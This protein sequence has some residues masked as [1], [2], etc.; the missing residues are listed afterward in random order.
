[1][2]YLLLALTLTLTIAPVAVT[3]ADTPPS[4][5]P[6][7]TSSH[8]WKHGS[9]GAFMQQEMQLRRQFRS[10]ALSALSTD[11]R[12]A[13]AGIIGTM[14]VSASPDP[15]AAAAQIDGVLNQSER[16]AILSAR[17]SFKQQSLA[18]HQQMQ[19]QMAQQMPG[20]QSS[21]RPMRTPGPS[22]NDPGSILLMALAPESGMGMMHGGGGPH[23]WPGGPPQGAP[24][25]D[26]A[27][28][29]GP[30]PN[31]APPDGGPP[32]PQP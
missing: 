20:A 5:P 23:G 15:R 11:H 1:M 2:R 9:F 13:I 10:H 26:G 32:P 19:S 12:N 8:A 25:P 16:Q 28:P 6:S 21:P 7:G 24:P 29:N 14:A 27:A 22:R 18:L 30:P 3:A 4:P 31:G 17:D